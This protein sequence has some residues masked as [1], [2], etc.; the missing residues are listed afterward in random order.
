MM[1]D[2]VEWIYTYHVIK[3][4]HGFGLC[5]AFNKSLNIISIEQE[6]FYEA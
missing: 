1:T 6:K 5:S 4:E 2:M 3:A